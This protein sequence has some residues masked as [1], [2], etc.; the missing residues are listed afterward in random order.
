MTQNG[1]KKKTQN[2]CQILPLKPKKT[3]KLGVFA[4]I[5][6]PLEALSLT[7]A[8]TFVTLIDIIS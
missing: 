1:P 3:Q 7:C 5:L 2:F 4:E 6:P 8:F